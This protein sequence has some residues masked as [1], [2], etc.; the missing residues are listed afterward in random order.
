MERASRG[1]RSQ[2]GSTARSALRTEKETDNCTGYSRL[3]E[4]FLLAFWV[5]FGGRLKA[6]FCFFPI[7]TPSLGLPCR[8]TS[9]KTCR[10]HG[11]TLIPHVRARRY[12]TRSRALAG[13][14]G[15]LVAFYYY[16]CFC[17]VVCFCPALEGAAALCARG[18]VCLQPRK[19]C[20]EGAGGRRKR[21]RSRELFVCFP[22]SL[23]RL[24][25]TCAALLLFVQ[26]RSS[27]VLMGAAG[28]RF[29]P[30]RTG[31]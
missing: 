24:H 21:G 23:K 27:A 20:K 3:Q 29:P 19:V 26:L 17:N 8:R 22:V 7:P 28:R 13:S 15:P 11:L 5:A 1:S 4:N 9:R 16:F 25:P 6:R 12:V 2:S 30:F 31:K 10:E 18:V 14:R